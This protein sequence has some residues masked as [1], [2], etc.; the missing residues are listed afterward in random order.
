MAE[1]LHLP[2]MERDFEVVFHVGY[3]KTA[4]TWLQQ[5]IFRDPA[6]GFIVPWSPEE[7]SGRTASAFYTV[8]S[9]DDDP[10]FTRSFFEEGLRRC[11]GESGVP[12]ISD[13]ALCG[14]PC[15]RVNNYTGR[16]IADR[17]HAAFPSAR[18]LIGIRE[19]KAIALSLYRQYLQACDG[20]FSLEFFL[21]RGDEPLGWTPILHPDYLEYDRIVA[22]YQ[23]L[24]GR[25]NV[26]VLPMEWL[27]KDPTA[28]VQSI[29]EFCRCPG[30]VESL[31]QARHVGQS[32]IALTFRRPLNRLFTA[33]P[34]SPKPSI[35][36][37][38]LNKLTRIVNRLAPRSWST[39]IERRW[40]E[41]VARRY[42]GR[43]A[44]SNR[45]LAD[46]TGLDL[47]ALGYEI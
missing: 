11:A 19:Q 43:F 13:E 20:I 14:D 5:H 6:T 22:H 27:Q 34:L 41:Q 31:A 42:T 28:Y 46:L 4:T 40:K 37:R 18:I 29:L 26:H 23:K 24:F 35:G 3:P 17:I 32:A 45:R 12:I 47:A 36:L 7:F 16:Y 38:I 9:Y 44:E 8:N 39:P 1:K 10:G 21:G 30:R 25:E 33:N 2:S 15:L